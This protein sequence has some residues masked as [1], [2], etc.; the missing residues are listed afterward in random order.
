MQFISPQHYCIQHVIQIKS[1]TASNLSSQITHFN[2]QQEIRIPRTL[3]QTTNFDYSK[4]FSFILS[5]QKDEQTK[6]SSFLKCD[7]P[8]PTASFAFSSHVYHPLGFQIS[9]I[10]LWIWTQYVPPESRLLCTNVYDVISQ[11]KGSSFSQPWETPTLFI[12]RDVLTAAP[13][14]KSS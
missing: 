9:K 8:L 5:S 1:H 12:Y 14:T 6:P 4:D 7:A 2:I 11:K 13:S 3:P 10:S